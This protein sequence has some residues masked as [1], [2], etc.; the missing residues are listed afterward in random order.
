V[1]Q[2]FFLL[3][4]CSVTLVFTSCVDKKQEGSEAEPNQ[5]S[6]PSINIFTEGSIGWDSKQICEAYYI[7]NGDTTKNSARIKCRGGA[8]SKYEKHSYSIEF[9]EAISTCG[10]PADDDWILNASYID[11]TFQ[12]HK[13]SYDLYRQMSPNNVA[14]ESGYVTV[15]VNEK[16]DGLYLAMEEINGSM[17]G[18]Y[19]ETPGALLFKDPPIFYKERLKIV[20][21]SNN[22]YQQK[23]PK[24]S[25]ENNE[26]ILDEFN[27]FMFNSNDQV[28]SKSISEWVD[29]ESIVD[30]HLI[31]LLTNNDDGLYKNFYLYKTSKNDPFKIAIWDYDHSFGRD[32]DGAI[33]MMEREVGWEKIVLLRRLMEI[34]EIGY[35]EKLKNRWEELRSNGVF[36]IENI[37]GMISENE[38]LI[39]PNLK[40]NFEKWPLDSKWYPD[41]NNYDK[42]IDIIKRFTK[43]RLKHLDEYMKNLE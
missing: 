42:E 3:F 22:Y 13:L 40:D 14:A 23:F 20:Q 4:F 1:R 2:S 29:I 8:S 21:D 39:K 43:M 38:I 36:T 27:E 9:D 25:N 19:A 34:E 12:R 37:E 18:F 11:K 7:L 6:I 17:L 28:F 24:I 32:G 41:D 33:N 30:W 35:R 31:L 15:F 26:A 10:I 16:Y 5:E